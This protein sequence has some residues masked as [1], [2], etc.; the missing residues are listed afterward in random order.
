M[1]ND[2][3]GMKASR[4]NWIF[5]TSIL[6]SFI[7]VYLAILV[8]REDALPFDDLTVMSIIAVSFALVCIGMTKA[9][10]DVPIYS[11]PM[12]FVGATFIYTL[13]GFILFPLD[14]WN[15][16]RNFIVI[17][18]AGIKQGL[19]IVMLAFSSFM[20]GTLALA[21][22]S[23]R[24]PADNPITN[25]T[26]AVLRRAGYLLYFFCMVLI[27]YATIQGAGI[28]LS[29]EGGYQEFA[30]YTT[31]NLFPYTMSATYAWFLPWAI[32]IIIG[33][34]LSRRQTLQALILA[35]AGIAIYLL[36]G[37]RTIP[38]ILLVLLIPARYLL[39]HP[40]SARQ[41]G[42]FAVLLLVIVSAWDAIRIIPVRDWTR[43]TLTRTIASE[44]F[45]VASS[46]GS[47]STYLEY[48]TPFGWILS[49]VSNSYQ[50][51]MG[52]VRLVP[53]VEPFHYGRD[54]LRATLISI[55][56]MLTRSSL[57]LG[58][59]PTAWITYRLFPETRSG[60]GFL[61]VG[62]AYVNF[63]AMGVLGLYLF[64]GWFLARSWYA[65]DTKATNPQLLSYYLI[66]VSTI[67]IWV[68]NDSGSIMRT[69]VWGWLIVYLIPF[70][71]TKIRKSA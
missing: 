29:F 26:V 52:A 9:I 30:T 6:F 62:E 48:R 59:A 41:I 42:I 4:S 20:L 16:F 51:L 60:L 27:G 40:F 3:N 5:T 13:S 50:T 53:D 35:L 45:G 37:D 63:G 38:T 10:L 17:D 70:V 19:P 49:N 44:S 68:R 43:E 46:G 66:L 18:E 24:V 71:I 12:I 67:L 25:D 47:E 58:E 61:Q 39:R 32:L 31:Q 55:P 34:S 22:K 28:N 69:V 56:F 65:L 8:V 7:T 54:Y 33:T 23:Q 14:G 57:D 15:A 21:R 11:F 64:M 2:I 1:Y 36:T